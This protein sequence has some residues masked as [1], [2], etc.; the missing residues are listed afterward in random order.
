MPSPSSTTTR[1]PRGTTPRHSREAT[2]RHSRESGNPEKAAADL[3]SGLHRREPCNDLDFPRSLHPL[4]QQVY[5]RRQ[6]ASVDDLQL[7][8]DNLPPPDL[9]KGMDTAAARLHRALEDKEKIVIVADFDADGALSCALALLALQAFGH[10][11]QRLD[12]I[13]P[14]RFRYGY[15]LSPKIVEDFVSKK[16]PNRSG[17]LITVDNGIA[18]IDGVA[19]AKERGIDTLITDHHLPGRHLPEAAAIVNPNQPGCAFPSKALAGVGVIFYVMLGLRSRLRER[20]W[21]KERGLSEPS[22]AELLDLVALGTVAD[23]VPLDRCNRIL[24][25]EGLKRIRA[26]RC[27]PGIEALLETARR[28][29]ASADTAD[30]GFGIGP[31]LNAAGRLTDM[32]VGIECLLTSDTDEARRLAEELNKLNNSRRQ[33]E[34]KMR[35]EALR[36]VADIHLDEGDLPPAICLFKEDWHQ[37][38]LGIV[39]S[40]IKER[41]HRPVIAFA[42][43]SDG[44]NGSDADEASDEGRASGGENESGELKGSAR[45]VTGFHIRDALDAVAT[46]H[47]GLINKFGGHA[48][49]AGLSLDAAN[50]ESFQSAFTAEAARLLDESQLTA[51]VQTD[52]PVPPAHL[53]MESATAL[54][55]AGPWGQAF[56][57]PLF[58]GRFQILR[59]QRLKDRHLKLTLRPIESSADAAVDASS[60]N[61]SDDSPRPLSCSLQAI[62]FNVPDTACPTPDTPEVHI[63]YRLE[64]NQYRGL[65]SLQLRVEHI[66][67]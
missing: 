5:L 28:S 3:P 6:L 4:L 65:R 67:L 62:A 39:A 35:E 41:Y 37:G 49:A 60:A 57:P 8:L 33:I 29:R 44:N 13:V 19:A 16:L 24:V 64:V 63:A 14:D 25:S 34:S 36:Q 42:R 53:N 7:T 15:G 12:Y 20:G 11:R 27:R 51:R 18:S 54:A 47:P 43:A 50:L 9:M 55:E 10:D 17:L 1:H 38:V 32:T 48:M 30:L 61:P 45:S 52:G 59:Q 56:P 23:V 40:R 46:R 22:L 26:G 66:F 2:T 31:R 58:D 21:F